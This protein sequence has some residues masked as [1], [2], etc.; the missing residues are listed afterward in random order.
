[1]NPG[2]GEDNPKLG[3]LETRQLENSWLVLVIKRLYFSYDIFTLYKFP[4]LQFSTRQVSPLSQ[5]SD[6]RLAERNLDLKNLR[7]AKD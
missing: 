5:L 1:M 2:V 4:R 3:N 6:R 7:R